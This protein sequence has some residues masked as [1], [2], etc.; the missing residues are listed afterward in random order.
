MQ[1]RT[2]KFNWRVVQ[3]SSGSC[4][5]VKLMLPHECSSNTCISDVLSEMMYRADN[6]RSS[7]L[8]SRLRQKNIQKMGREVGARHELDAE[9]KFANNYVVF[10]SSLETR[11]VPSV[12]ELP[13]FF[14]LMFGKL[15]PE[16]ELCCRPP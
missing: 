15:S 3:A 16:T 6:Q 1:K 8:T 10:R 7:R 4:A 9:A 5:H 11:T 13:I 14:V 2:T 12:L